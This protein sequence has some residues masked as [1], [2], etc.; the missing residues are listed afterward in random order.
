VNGREMKMK[1]VK[2]FSDVPRGQPL[3]Y[4]DSRGRMALAVNQNNFAAV[5]GVQPP[6]ELLIPRS[7]K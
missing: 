1:F 5:Y 6:A 2:T 7:A 4:V 3:L